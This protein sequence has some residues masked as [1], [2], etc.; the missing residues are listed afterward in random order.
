MRGPKKRFYSRKIVQLTDEL[1]RA[2]EAVADAEDLSDADVIRRAL[3]VY[4]RQHPQSALEA[5]R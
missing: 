5:Q 4:F 1:D 2:V 3:I